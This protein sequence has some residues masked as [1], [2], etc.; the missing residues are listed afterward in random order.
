MFRF[1][2][3][4]LVDYFSFLYRNDSMLPRI[5]SRWSRVYLII[6][7]LFE[8]QMRCIV[9]I[10]PRITVIR[11]T[12]SRPWSSGGKRGMFLTATLRDSIAEKNTD[13]FGNAYSWSC[14]D[15]D[16]SIRIDVSTF[17]SIVDLKWPKTTIQFML[18]NR[19]FRAKRNLSERPTVM[20]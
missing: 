6:G 14:N 8:I 2:Q 9:N 13:G 17:G 3:P 7:H 12:K 15:M 11:I 18:I 5:R 1:D 19:G 4:H 16:G 20:L 10:H